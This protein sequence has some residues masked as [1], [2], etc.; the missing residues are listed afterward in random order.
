MRQSLGDAHHLTLLLP[1]SSSALPLR[2]RKSALDSELA[3]VREKL[4]DAASD[5]R[6]REGEL[7][8]RDT[9]ETLR[10][11]FPSVRSSLADLCEVNNPKYEV[12]MRIVF[13]R[14]LDSIVVGDQQTALECIH[15]LK[16]QRLG[17]ATFIPLD[18]IKV[19]SISEATRQ[20]AAKGFPL[21]ID[22]ITYEADLERAFIY[23]LSDTLLCDSERDEASAIKKATQLAFGS[24]RPIDTNKFKIVTLGGTVIHKSGNITGGASSKGD[25]RAGKLRSSAEKSASKAVISEREYQKLTKRRDELVEE[26]LKVEAETAAAFRQQDEESK[27]SAR[28]RDNDMCRRW[29]QKRV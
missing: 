7:K 9:I 15:Y 16:E 29:K 23:A 3:T 20:M 2:A 19:K 8:L 5:R 22:C 28:V 4:A 21:A 25:G 1:V 11:H 10:A 18:T 6:A 27:L 12:A 26:L 13:G 24:G 17:T 14:H